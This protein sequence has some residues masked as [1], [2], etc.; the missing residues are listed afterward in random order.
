[1]E[2]PNLRDVR[3]AHDRIRP[4][5][6]RTPVLTSASINAMVGARALF[7]CENFQKV[8]AFKFRGATNAVFSLSDE[9]ANRGVVTHSSGN[10]AAALALAAR[11]RGISARIVM[12]SNAPSVK[13]AAVEGYGGNITFCEPK[14]LAREEAADLIV[15]ETGSTLVH[16]SNDLSVITGQGTVALEFIETAGDLD[17][18]LTPLGGGGLLSGTALTVRGLG[19]KIKVVGCE[20]K[21]ADDAYRSIR[22]GRILPSVNPDTI[23]DGLRTSLGDNTFSIIRDLVDDIVLVS[24]EEIVAAMQTIF[25]RM[26]IVVEPSSAV[27]VA[28]VLFEKIRVTDKNVGIILSGGNVDFSQFFQGML[29]NPPPQTPRKNDSNG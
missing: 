24:E 26:K 9:E 23:A 29:G 2:R 3:E 15:K 5:I 8:G 19:A 7:K 18:I 25:Q 13:I 27:P 22:A 11:N 12:P 20:P 16:P 4:Y 21:N 6:H 1:M 14:P 28:A 17:V 10:H